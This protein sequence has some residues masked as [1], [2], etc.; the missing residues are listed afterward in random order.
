MLMEFKINKIKSLKIF[1]F[2]IIEFIKD[3]Y[4]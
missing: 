1:E 4:F 2:Q 3:E